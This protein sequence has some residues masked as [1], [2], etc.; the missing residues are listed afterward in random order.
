MADKVVTGCWACGKLDHESQDCAFKRCFVCAEQ[1]HESRECTRRNQWCQR[2]RSSGHL[3]ESCPI[4]D[5]NQGIESVDD[6][7]YCRC[8]VCCSEGHLNCSEVGLICEEPPWKKRFAHQQQP[9]QQTKEIQ[10]QSWWQRHHQPSWQAQRNDAWPGA[11]FDNQPRP[12]QPRGPRPVA[13]MNRKESHP[14]AMDQLDHTDSDD[15]ADSG[16]Y[17]DNGATSLRGVVRPVNRN[18]TPAPRLPSW[19]QVTTFDDRVDTQQSEEDCEE[20]ETF[21][22]RGEDHDD[23]V[24]DHRVGWG[25][26]VSKGS[27]KSKSYSVSLGAS[28]LIRPIRPMR[29]PAGIIGLSNRWT[30]GSRNGWQHGAR[31]ASSGDYWQQRYGRKYY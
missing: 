21:G 16:P 18:F 29:P 14:Q 2:C 30:S 24:Q 5:Y 15:V 11:I 17:E 26:G 4:N 3:P 23:E 6:V 9:Q 10:S 12:Q 1:G 19:R 25:A 28:A 31:D 7:A 27:G 13:W 8:V 20:A 22:Y